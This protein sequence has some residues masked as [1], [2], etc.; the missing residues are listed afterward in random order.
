MPY[1]TIIWDILARDMDCDGSSLVHGAMYMDYNFHS[2]KSRGSIIGFIQ[3]NKIDSYLQ[4]FENNCMSSLTNLYSLLRGGV[5][6]CA[7]THIISALLHCSGISAGEM[8]VIR[9]AWF[10]LQSSSSRGGFQGCIFL[11]MLDPLSGMR[12]RYSL[13]SWISSVLTIQ[14]AT[15]SLIT[16]CSSRTIV[17]HWWSRLPKSW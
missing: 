2:F 12:Y 17:S 7:C 13:P 14:W 6:V 8:D 3:S 11:S 15:G 16:T 10:L 4:N 9:K 1:S 5:C